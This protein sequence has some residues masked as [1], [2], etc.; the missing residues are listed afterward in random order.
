MVNARAN[1]AK[2]RFMVALTVNEKNMK[3]VC[4]WFQIDP[5]FSQFVPQVLYEPTVYSTTKAA[6]GH[7]S[8][9]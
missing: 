4:L 5:N 3:T 8:Y 7:N 1:N 2:R 6:A 9:C